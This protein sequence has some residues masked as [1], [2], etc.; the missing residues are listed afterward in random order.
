VGCCNIASLQ[1]ENSKLDQ[2]SPRMLSSFTCSPIESGKL[3]VKSFTHICFSH[4]VRKWVF[5]RL[6]RYLIQPSKGP[7]W[8]LI[9]LPFH[10]IFFQLSFR[11]QI[12]SSNLNSLMILSLTVWFAFSYSWIQSKLII[13]IRTTCPLKIKIKIKQVNIILIRIACKIICSESF[14][15]WDRLP[16]LFQFQSSNL[17]NKSS[18]HLL[19]SDFILHTCIILVSNGILQFEDWTIWSFDLNLF[20]FHF[21]T[22]SI[23]SS[24]SPIFEQLGHSILY[25]AKW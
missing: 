2:H 23:D 9:I 8:I 6:I 1:A 18:F 4:F 21:P 12:Q 16:I 7:V 25:S 5:I 19:I 10:P 17:E 3:K 11:F 13:L 20:R 24:K 15:I 14:L 22:F